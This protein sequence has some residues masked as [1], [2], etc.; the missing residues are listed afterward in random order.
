MVNSTAANQ[1]L[2]IIVSQAQLIQDAASV[3]QY[4]VVDMIVH[5]VPFSK[6]FYY[7]PFFTMSTSKQCGLNN[8]ATQELNTKD[9]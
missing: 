8:T 3:P 2:I 1:C 7:I 9:F 5:I 6:W 4:I